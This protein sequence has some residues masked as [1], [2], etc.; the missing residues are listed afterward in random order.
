MLSSEEKAHLN[1]LVI[2]LSQHDEEAT[3]RAEEEL[4]Y[5]CLSSKD[6]LELLKKQKS[7]ISLS[8]Q[9][10][11]KIANMIAVATMHKQKTQLC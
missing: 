7:D 3:Q 10:R 8:G 1:A 2:A 6:A 4:L 5:W 9:A 11:Y